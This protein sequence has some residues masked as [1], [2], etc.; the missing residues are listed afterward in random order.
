MKHFIRLKEVL[1]LFWI[2]FLQSAMPIRCEISYGQRGKLFA[3][4]IAWVRNCPETLYCFEAVTDDINKM[5]KLIDY[6][7]VREHV[8]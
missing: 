3:D 1:F 4:K 8:H 6:P 5:K 7:W 2:L